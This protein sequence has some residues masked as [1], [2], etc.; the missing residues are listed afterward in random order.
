M[1]ETAEATPVVAAEP[2]NGEAG[3]GGGIKTDDKIVTATV[4]GTAEGATE[5]A[6]AQVA[7][8]DGGGNEDDDGD[9]N[10]AGGDKMSLNKAGSR[11]WSRE[12]GSCR[13]V[14]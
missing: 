4:V 9:E 5:G 13:N 8:S 6:A 14:T 11:P 12:V 1:T 10:G 2:A 3:E 7:A